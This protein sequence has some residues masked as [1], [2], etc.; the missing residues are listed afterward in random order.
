MSEPSESIRTTRAHASRSWASVPPWYW[1]HAGGVDGSTLRA[2]VTAE[3]TVVEQ[4][5]QIATLLNW[6]PDKRADKLWWGI[7]QRA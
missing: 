6:G 2:D 3:G 4:P 1:F 5:V 7:K